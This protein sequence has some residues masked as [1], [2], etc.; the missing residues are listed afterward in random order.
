MVVAYT[1]SHLYL[2]QSFFC[3]WHATGV[4]R[5]VAECSS[6]VADANSYPTLLSR[7]AFLWPTLA[8]HRPQQGLEFAQLCKCCMMVSVVSTSWLTQ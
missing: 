5:G 3:C 4:L 1:V 7:N 8:R 2:L 6:T